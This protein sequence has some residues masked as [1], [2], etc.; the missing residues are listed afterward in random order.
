M[1]HHDIMASIARERVRELR[2]RG[3]AERRAAAVRRAREYW[4]ERLSRHMPVRAAR[5]PGGTAAAP[6]R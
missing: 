2:E 3:E 1:F 4:D 5:R 6:G